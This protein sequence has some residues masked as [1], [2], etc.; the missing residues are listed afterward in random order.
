[1]QYVNF[2]SVLRLKNVKFKLYFKKKNQRGK[3]VWNII[4]VDIQI[5]QFFILFQGGNVPSHDDVSVV[6]NHLDYLITLLLLEIRQ[7]SGDNETKHTTDSTI[8]TNGR[9][10]EQLLSENLLDKLYE[11]GSNTGRL[12]LFSNLINFS[13]HR[14]ENK[15]ENLY[16]YLNVVRL[17]QLKLYSLLVQHFGKQLICAE[18]FLRPLLKLLRSFHTDIPTPDVE[19]IYFC[20]IAYEKKII[21]HNFCSLILFTGKLVSLLGQ[22]CVVLMQNPHYVDL[23]FFPPPY[24]DSVE[25]SR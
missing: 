21:L 6:I 16:R 1:M 24:E 7:I 10:L 17:E 23:F 8:N 15:I 19:G 3:I 13:F 4:F 25:K 5:V 20:S 2:P 11:W 12:Y 14:P 9:C 18:P 22:V